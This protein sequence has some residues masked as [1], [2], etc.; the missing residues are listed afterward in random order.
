MNAFFAFRLTATLTLCTLLSACSTLAPVTP[1]APTASS[2]ELRQQVID[3]ERA[4]ART[5][6]DRDHAAFAG[7]I[8]DDTIFYSP[9]AVRGKAAVVAA[10]KRFYD[11]PAAPFSWEPEDVEVLDS[12]LLAISSGPVKNAK[13]ELI[14]T[15]TSIWRREPS[16]QWRVI[17]DKGNNACEKCAKPAP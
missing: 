12:G 9:K 17:F 13:G 2:A 3:V 8:A 5:M 15:F 10:W 11:T 16:G 4:F 7:F 6:A 14:A 1:V